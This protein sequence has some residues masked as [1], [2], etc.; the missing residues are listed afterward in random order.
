V[1]LSERFSPEER[2]EMRSD[3]IALLSQ[4]PAEAVFT[5]FLLAALDVLDQETD[6]NVHRVFISW[7]RIPWTTRVDTIRTNPGTPLTRFVQ[8]VHTNSE[9]G[10]Q[11]PRGLLYRR[12]DLI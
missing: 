11:L 4:A 8:Q 7:L 12:P 10:N 6:A 2:E 1:N 9:F 3:L 5:R